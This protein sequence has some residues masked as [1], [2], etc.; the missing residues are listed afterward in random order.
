[1]VALFVVVSVLLGALGLSLVG[2]GV[3]MAVEDLATGILGASFGALTLYGAYLFGRAAWRTRRDLIENPPT[4]AE[5]RS[6]RRRAGAVVV[7]I[8]LA[9]AT[10]VVAESDDVA[11]VFFVIMAVVAI[12]L[13][14]A[15]EFE[16]TRRTR[17][18]Q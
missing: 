16:P 6:R 1:M 14:L 15:A 2:L 7:A 9:A 11:R 3:A 8:A 18:R 4:T 17:R 13:I 10:G 5:R 12:P